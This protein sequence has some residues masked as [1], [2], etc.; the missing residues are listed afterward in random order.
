VYPAGAGAAVT[1]CPHSGQNLAPAGSDAPQLGHETASCAP[2]C[3]QKRASSGVSW[4]HRGHR[5]GD[6]P[7]PT[8]S[9][10]M[11]DPFRIAQA[12]DTSR[13]RLPACTALRLRAIKTGAMLK[14]S[15]ATGLALA[16]G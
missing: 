9:G 12:Q 15:P 7:P 5:T 11:P 13:V 16:N 6:H 4:L 2:Q 3:R 10:D 1:P 14:Q 8:S